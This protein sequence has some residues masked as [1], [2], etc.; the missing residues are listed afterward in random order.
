MKKLIFKIVLGLNKSPKFI[1]F[2]ENSGIFPS[3]YFRN[4]WEVIRQYR[5]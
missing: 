2:L 5:K 3:H 4:F 1:S